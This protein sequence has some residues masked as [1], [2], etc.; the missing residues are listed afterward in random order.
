MRR[1]SSTFQY[2]SSLIETNIMLRK[3][4]ASICIAAVFVGCAENPADNVPKAVAGAPLGVPGSEVP[5]TPATE[6][7]PTPAANALAFDPASSKIEFVGSK[8]TGSHAGGFKTFTGGV[9]LSEDG[10]LIKTITATIDMNSTFSDNDGLTNHLK[11]QDFFDVPKFPSS[12]FKTTEIK[13]GGEGGAT[14]TIVGDLTLHGVT[15]S[16][17]FPAT[18]AVSDSEVT[19][20]SEFAINRFDFEI[21]TPGKT[22]DLIRKEV[23]LKLD[24]KATKAK[25]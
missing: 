12:T 9:E 10:K 24:L 21:V 17:S 13:A 2:D 1:Q 25:S 6:A 8:V 11:N 5:A 20:K 16:I 19:L 15:K 14:H 7:T 18:V 22:D 23:V 4:F 3:A